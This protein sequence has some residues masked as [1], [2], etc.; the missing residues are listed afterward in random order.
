MSL[1]LHTEFDGIAALRAALAD[2][3]I[4][5]TDLAQS[6]LAAIDARQD[7]NAFLHA[8]KSSTA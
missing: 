6:A 2:R 1:P 7:L 8:S 4:C 5:A 3:R